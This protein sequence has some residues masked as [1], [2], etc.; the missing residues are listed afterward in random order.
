MAEAGGLPESSFDT[1]GETVCEDRANVRAQECPA[2]EIMPKPAE[3]RA[4]GGGIGPS[5]DCN[6]V[7][8]SESLHKLWHRAGWL[9]VL[10]MC[11]STS[12]VVLEN[13]EPLIKSHPVVVYFLTMLVGAGGNAGSQSTV[14][15]VRRLA[16]AAVGGRGRASRDRGLSVRR[17][18]GSEL[19]VGAKLSIV[20]CCTS[21][22]RCIAFQVRGAECLTICLS[23]LVIV[24]TSTMVGAALPLLLRRLNMDPAHASAAIQVVMDI[25]GVALTCAVSSRVLGLPLSGKA[26]RKAVVEAG[27][28]SSMG[29]GPG[30]SVQ[31]ETSHALIRFAM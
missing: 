4:E 19:S 20:L 10:L 27:Y 5:G 3:P 28:N 13:F 22:V 2:F 11:Q 23:M 21:F 7:A 25:S 18:V 15:V 9:V 29:P 1:E 12:S 31:Q 6:E 24:F 14:L 30:I 16:L 26:G 17:I 8:D